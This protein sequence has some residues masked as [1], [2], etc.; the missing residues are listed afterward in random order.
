[1]KAEDARGTK[2]NHDRFYICCYEGD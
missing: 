1:M 2:V